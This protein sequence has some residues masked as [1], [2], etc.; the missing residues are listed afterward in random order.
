MGRDNRNEMRKKHR[1]KKRALKM[2]LK[3]IREKLG[4]NLYPHQWEQVPLPQREHLLRQVF[5]ERYTKPQS[6][7]THATI[8]SAPSASQAKE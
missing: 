5:P 2:K 4:I 7:S 8:P 3:L 1:K 6:I